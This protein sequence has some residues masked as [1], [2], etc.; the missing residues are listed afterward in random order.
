MI[1]VYSIVRSRDKQRG[2]GEWIV[3]TTVGT[4]RCFSLCLPETALQKSPKPI[5]AT[6]L[7]S[8]N[9]QLT[10]HKDFLRFNIR[11]R[12]QGL[13]NLLSQIGAALHVA[14]ATVRSLFAELGGAP[15][16][17]AENVRRNGLRRVAN[18]QADDA[19][20]HFRMFGHVG[21]SAAS[22]FGKEVA[23]R[24]FGKVGVASDHA[25][26]RRSGSAAGGRPPGAHRGRK[27]LDIVAGRRQCYSCPQH[28][29]DASSIGGELH[30]WASLGRF[31]GRGRVGEDLMVR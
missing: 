17:T 16:Q 6:A 29:K 8:Y 20:G 15:G 13:G 30:A 28:R 4:L 18:P 23:S 24:E 19:V 2:K 31:G 11:I 12:I 10:R 25:K 7:A 1:V 21:G 5:E 14:V 27:G 3:R 9:N 22:N 26:V